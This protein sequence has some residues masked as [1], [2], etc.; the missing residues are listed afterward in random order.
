M[1]AHG[2][3]NQYKL[4]QHS[5]H[6]SS[7]SQILIHPPIHISCQNCRSDLGGAGRE[8]SYSTQFSHQGA[9]DQFANLPTLQFNSCFWKVERLKG[10]ISNVYTQTGA[11]CSGHYMT[12]ET[13]SRKDLQGSCLP[14]EETTWILYL[15]VKSDSSKCCSYLQLT[16]QQA[17]VCRPRNVSSV[18]PTTL[19][20]FF[21]CTFI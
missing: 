19:P 21:M 2:L 11:S 7:L 17:G 9:L 16:L 20:A 12:S 5:T 18:L 4:H 8:E 3:E 1:H 6:F 14:K 10:Y 15:E 13:V